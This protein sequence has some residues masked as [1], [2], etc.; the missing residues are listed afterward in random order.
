MKA[1]CILF[2]LILPVISNAEEIGPLDQIEIENPVLNGRP[3][4]SSGVDG[5]YGV[6]R[7][8]GYSFFDETLSKFQNQTDSI[9]CWRYSANGDNMI[10]SLSMSSSRSI[11]TKVVC[12]RSQN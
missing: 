4:C 3:F 12:Y 5:A 2:I 11:V 6:C 7:A 1:I 9:P 8:K 10:R